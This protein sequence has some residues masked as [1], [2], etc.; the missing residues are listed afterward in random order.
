MANRNVTVD[1]ENDDKASPT[2]S[3]KVLLIDVSTS[4]DSL[5]EATLTNVLALATADTITLAS[6]MA[7]GEYSGIAEAGTAGTTLSFG[8]LVYFSVTDS[9]WELADCDAESTAGPV[10]L[11]I[12]VLAAAADGSA[13]TVLLYGK[14]RADS[15]FPTF[16]IG[17]PVYISATAGDV[18]VAQPASTR[19]TRVIGYGNTADE[20]FFCPSN[21]YGLIRTY[22]PTLTNTTNL[23]ASTAYTTYYTRVGNRVDVWGKVEGDPTSGSTNTVLGF[24]IPVASTL[25]NDYD[26]A[27][28]GAVVNAAG[29]RAGVTIAGDVAN[30]RATFSWY[31]PDG[32]NRAIFFNFS[33]YVI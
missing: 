12:C 3:D 21:E 20:L 27:G 24:S 28:V 10:K 23:A 4:P 2:L 14:V 13:T 17:A 29:E 32:S 15:A 8:D 16:T 31:A 7:D 22:T 6:S 1:A 26:L 11:G 33:Y 18:V 9:R 25:A 30:A 5:K 19:V